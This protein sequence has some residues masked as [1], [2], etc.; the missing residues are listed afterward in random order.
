MSVTDYRTMI[1]LDPEGDT[2]ATFE[3]SDGHT[4]EFSVRDPQ[5]IITASMEPEEIR[6]FIHALEGA[7][8]AIEQS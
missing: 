2:I 4:L 1:D 8:N 5:D 6:N 3:V 7:L